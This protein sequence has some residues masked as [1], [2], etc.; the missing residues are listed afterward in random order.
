MSAR[1]WQQFRIVHIS[2]MHFGRHHFFNPPG[3][4]AESDGQALGL[5]ILKDLAAIEAE[6]APRSPVSSEASDP[7]NA[8]RVIFA[9]TGDFNE[10][11]TTPEFEKS[12]TFL[13]GFYHS[14]VFRR[15][16]KPSDIFIIPGNHDLKYAEDD[17]GVRW[18]QFVH[19]YQDHY[20]LRQSG[21][22]DNPRRFDSRDPLVLTTIVDQSSD[23]L[24]VAEINSC[25]YVQKE[26]VDERRGQVHDDALHS[27]EQ[28]LK[29]IDAKARHESIK[30]ALIH[31][32]PVVL[33]VLYEPDAGYDGVLNS[34]GLFQ[35]LKKY[36]FHLVLHGHKH[37][38]VTYSYDAV[39]A[40]TTDGVQP[41][42]VVA[43]GSAGSNEIPRGVP[44]TYNVIDIKW[45]PKTSQ[46]RVNIKTRGHVST[47]EHHRRMPSPNWYW[48]TL[49][50]DDRLL[51]ASNWSE[52][53][54]FETRDWTEHDEGREVSRFDEQKRLRRNF[55]CV[56]I[57]PSLHEGQAYEARLWI[58]GQVDKRDYELPV[59]VE[60][61]ASREYFKQIY[62]REV[63][64]DPQFRA[65]FAYYGPTLIQARMIWKDGQE[66]LAYIFAH[67]PRET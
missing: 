29:A 66:E 10:R 39:S 30:V 51:T 59:R 36:G 3:N 64:A 20:D 65:V 46:A 62:V 40:W 56:E 2:D 9:L 26:T 60:W 43:G 16:I 15:T 32:H 21:T 17:P 54:R 50:V 13:K 1:E 47:D 52:A 11:C 5:S 38:A 61:A 49:R 67:F 14:T 41:L 58:N 63:V 48:K 7:A 23:G 33:P 18:S 35:L 44:N 27:L 53:S 57:V 22:K 45:H 4:G 42:L 34:D 28:Q 8:P 25:A 55:P 12:K 6:L 31:H 19:F 37:A 24:I